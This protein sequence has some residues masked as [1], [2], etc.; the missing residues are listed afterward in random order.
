[1][2]FLIHIAIIT[3][4]FGVAGCASSS[5]STEPAAAAD[6]ECFKIR[7]IRKW[8]IIDTR[9]LY[10]ESYGTNKKF[11]YTM[12]AVCPGIENTKTVWMSG[13]RDTICTDNLGELLY[14]GSVMHE[15]CPVARIE[16][17]SGQDQAESLANS[18]TSGGT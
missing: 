14:R 13:Y 1:M 12:G 4:F 9:H 17:V 8:R 11:L 5:T 7:D 2:K 16:K 18:R 6:K 15:S 3:I 10:V